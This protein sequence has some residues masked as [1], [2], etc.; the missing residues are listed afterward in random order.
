M[1]RGSC[2]LEALPKWASH[3]S[4]LNSAR[5]GLPELCA[6]CFQYLEMGQLSLLPSQ[7]RSE[8][9]PVRGQ[10]W[11]DRVFWNHLLNSGMPNPP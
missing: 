8:G 11:V 1:P 4:V 10:V 2:C 5:A 7:S 6:G 3:H 9:L